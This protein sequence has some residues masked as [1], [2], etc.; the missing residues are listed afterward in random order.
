MSNLSRS[1]EAQV[2]FVIEV[3]VTTNEGKVELA[4][5]EIERVGGG[6]DLANYSVRFAVNRGNT[7]IGL[8]QRGVNDFLRTKFNVLGLLTLAL[9]TLDRKELELDEVD[10]A[11]MAREERRTLPAL[12]GKASGRVHHHRPSLRRRQSE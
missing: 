2:S 1:T 9:A 3:W 10:P 6:E 11:D 8:H 12:S 5:I 7:W 4:H